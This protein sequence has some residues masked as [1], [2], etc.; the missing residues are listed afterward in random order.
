M[1]SKA[2]RQPKETVYKLAAIVPQKQMHE[3]L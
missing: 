3:Y 2:F 1:V